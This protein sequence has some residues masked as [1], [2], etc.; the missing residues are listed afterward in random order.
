ML[1]VEEEEEHK[2]QAMQTTPGDAICDWKLRRR[3]NLR[4]TSE[5]QREESRNLG[6][7]EIS[8]AEEEEILP[9]GDSANRR[10]GNSVERR[11]RTTGGEVDATD[12]DGATV[13][14]ATDFRRW[15]QGQTARR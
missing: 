15:I 5:S 4:Q 1:E 7:E 13:D 2:L 3:F 11:F 12:F 8:D 14:G 9:E 6:R 10:G